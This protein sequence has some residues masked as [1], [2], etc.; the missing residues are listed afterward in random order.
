MAQINSMLKISVLIS[1]GQKSMFL[2]TYFSFL[3]RDVQQLLG[4]NVLL[5][6]H[7]AEELLLEAKLKSHILCLHISHFAL[8]RERKVVSGRQNETGK[9]AG[10]L[11]VML[12]LLPSARAREHLGA[13]KVGAPLI[14]KHY[15]AP[16]SMCLTHSNGNG[17]P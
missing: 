13:V 17:R 14:L 2:K 4:F 9:L 1:S 8:K 16:R 7:S 12:K 5:L 10:Y 11:R 15:G 6:I 3:L